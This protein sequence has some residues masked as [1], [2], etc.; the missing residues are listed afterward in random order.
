MINVKSEKGF[1][2]KN[3]KDYLD[4]KTND[5]KDV[6]Y[7]SLSFSRYKDFNELALSGYGSKGI[8]FTDIS[9]LIDDKC[10]G[11]VKDVNMLKT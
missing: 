3:P 2:N 1:Y 10:Y 6:R 4:G 7:R 5:F 11:K 8:R 9:I